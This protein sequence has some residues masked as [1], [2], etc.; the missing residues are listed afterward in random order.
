MQYQRPM[1]DRLNSFCLLKNSCFVDR[2]SLLKKKIAESQVKS[3]GPLKFVRRRNFLINQYGA[4][5][6]PFCLMLVGNQQ[7]NQTLLNNFF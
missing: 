4:R 7:R 6:F 3:I 5:H 1:Q 2:G